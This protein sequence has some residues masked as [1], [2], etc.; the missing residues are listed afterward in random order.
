MKR[1]FSSMKKQATWHQRS[2][3]GHKREEDILI[4][5]V[6]REEH[7]HDAAKASNEFKREFGKSLNISEPM[8]DS[9]RQKGLMK[10]T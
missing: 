10:T 3:E 4:Q 8:D 5:T 6:E 1:L 7:V 9:W 2:K